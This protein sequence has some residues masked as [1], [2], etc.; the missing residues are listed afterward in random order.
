M[1]GPWGELWRGTRRRAFGRDFQD[2]QG[3]RTPRAP[4][5]LLASSSCQAP[6]VLGGCLPSMV[7]I[8]SRRVL[9]AA[10][11]HAFSAGGFH[12]GR[13][14]VKGRVAWVAVARDLPRIPFAMSLAVEGRVGGSVT[15]VVKLGR[16]FFL[17]NGVVNA[18]FGGLENLCLP[19]GIIE[20]RQH[21]LPGPRQRVA[22]PCATRVCGALLNRRRTMGK[23]RG[24]SSAIHHTN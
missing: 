5:R 14:V 17:G 8:R 4:A 15:R 19:L 12:V 24:R 16:V 20:P 18:I 3:S 6:S 23:A 9:A 1:E 2:S 10:I 21:H 13:P 11:G 7:T 22:P